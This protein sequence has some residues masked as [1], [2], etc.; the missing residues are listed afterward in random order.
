MQSMSQSCLPCGLV[1]GVL[2]V[3]GRKASSSN[4]VLMF[5]F[6]TNLRCFLPPG[7]A[8]DFSCQNAAWT[9]QHRKKLEGLQ[10]MWLLG[11]QSQVAPREELGRG[12][13]DR[14]LSWS[15]GQH[16]SNESSS[17]WLNI[18]DLWEDIKTNKQTENHRQQKLQPLRHTL[19]IVANFVFIFI[20]LFTLGL[21]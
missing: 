6:N 16:P 15:E 1:L 13:G 9:H 10:Q 3:Q 21:I 5:P 2:S 4:G 14:L 18:W 7:L 20:I 17:S 12:C 11:R 8:D 19:R